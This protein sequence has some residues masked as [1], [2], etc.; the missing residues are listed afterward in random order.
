VE[1]VVEAVLD[2]R[3]DGDLGA[4]EQLLHRL[5][6]N[7]GGVVADGLQ[8]LRIVAHDQFEVAGAAQRAVQVALF[9]V[10]SDQRRAL[11]QRRRDGGG[12][13]TAR[14]VVGILARCAVGEFEVDHVFVFAGGTGSYFQP[15]PKGW[16]LQRRLAVSHPP[17]IGPC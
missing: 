4:G 10:Q 2:R 16:H 3:A 12:D 15:S 9:A 11:G 13:V 5:G 14:G 8:R 7:V 1:V 6:Q 17:L